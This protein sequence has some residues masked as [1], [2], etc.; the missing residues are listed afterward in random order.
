M[1]Q[2][3]SSAKTDTFRIRINPLI[4]MELETVYAKNGLTLTDA[5]NVFFQQSL[6]AGGFPFPV[7]ENNAEIVK[8]KALS[9]LM[10]ELEKGDACE[11]SYAED[12]ACAILGIE[13]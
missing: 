8:A 13:L 1:E 9:R 7:V 4:R 3:I 6:N 11:E 2:I 10:K 5:V 12:E